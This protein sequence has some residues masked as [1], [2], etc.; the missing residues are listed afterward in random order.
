LPASHAVHGQRLAPGRILV[1]PPDHHLLVRDG[2]AVLSRGPRQNRHRPAVDALFTSAAREC[3]P[4]TIAVV[5]SGALDDGAAGAAAVAA[6]DGTVM[7]QSPSD[8]RVPGMPNAALAAVRRARVAPAEELGG[9]LADAVA[10]Q[11]G[12]VTSQ[13]ASMAQPREGVRRHVALGCPD[14][15]G[16]MFE[17]QPDTASFVCHVGHSWSAETLLNAQEETVESALY[18]AASKLLE[19]A[20]VHQRLA[21]LALQ[22]SGEQSERVQRH[23]E[24]AAR[25]ERQ[26]ERVQALIDE[27]GSELDEARPR[28]GERDGEGELAG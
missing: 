19:S 15:H 3:G 21:E 13:E 9:L 1:A 18:N 26:S 5:L 25:A 2:A 6:Q 17:L 23:I 4:A 8:A 27:L 16:G 11:L 14:C 28:E 22:G 20:Y 12:G 10:R 7:V 24:A